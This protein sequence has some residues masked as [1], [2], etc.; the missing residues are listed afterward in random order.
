MAAF[1]FACDAHHSLKSPACSCVSI[2]L[3]LPCGEQKRQKRLDSKANWERLSFRNCLQGA[4]NFGTLVKSTK[5]RR[6]STLWRRRDTKK[7]ATK[8]S[9]SKG[10]RRTGKKF[11]SKPEKKSRLAE[12]EVQFNQLMAST[13]D[14]QNPLV[15][16][17]ARVL[18]ERMT[19]FKAGEIKAEQ[20][21]AT[22]DI[23][24]ETIQALAATTPSGD[25]TP[26]RAATERQIFTRPIWLSSCWKSD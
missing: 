17:N 11:G 1:C 6:L 10:K 15:R 26:N 2:T 20:V 3:S 5:E 18:A 4:C 22:I 23:Q 25:R 7:R 24:I 16:E 14:S 9:R 19:Q 13:Q 8:K 21:K 12:L